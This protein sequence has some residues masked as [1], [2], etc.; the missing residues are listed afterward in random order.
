MA[1]DKTAAIRRELTKLKKR[2]GEL[3]PSDVVD[4]ARDKKTALHSCFEWNDG[5]A[6]HRY[7]LWQ[8]QHVI[9]VHVVV[10]DPGNGETVVHPEFV[11]IDRND[12]YRAVTDVLQE[13]DAKTSLLQ[14]TIRRLQSIKEVSLF[15][16]ELGDVST[17]IKLAAEKYNVK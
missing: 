4:F 8:A 17:A 10:I 12:A 5:E 6:A 13:E 7:R 1:T 16:D 14:Q 3:K 11:S 2:N 9:R 15:P